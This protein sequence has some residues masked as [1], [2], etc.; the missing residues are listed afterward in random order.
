MSKT[1]YWDD[2]TQSTLV[3]DCTPEEEAE[4]AARKNA[5]PPVPQSVTRR[6]ALSALLLADKL[7]SVQPAID[8]IPDATQRGLMQIEWDESQTFERTRPAL[9]QMAAALGMT[10]VELDQLFITA[11]TL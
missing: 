3:R 5:P 6:Q 7:D 10:D 11:A 4:I 9:L 1:A 2:A 8:A